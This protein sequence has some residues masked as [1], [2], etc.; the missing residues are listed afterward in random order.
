MSQARKSVPVVSTHQ[1][2]IYQKINE[3]I[4]Y[5]ERDGIIPAPALFFNTKYVES[6]GMLKKLSKDLPL[7]KLALQEEQIKHRQEWLDSFSS[8][9]DELQDLVQKR[10]EAAKLVDE[11]T[12]EFRSKK[13]AL[14]EV[15]KKVREDKER[16]AGDEQRK[17]TM[18]A[19][20]RAENLGDL[21]AQKIELGKKE[22]V[23]TGK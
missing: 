1:E 18:I 10:R 2:M 16:L 9:G 22:D 19:R 23:I 21:E 5:C 7:V 6:H 15:K 12:I 20:K 11:M 4:L 13:V 3:I 14:E 8:R 17:A